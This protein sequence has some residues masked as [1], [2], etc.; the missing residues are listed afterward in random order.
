MD[1]NDSMI[2]A[3]DER[4]ND[5]FETYDCKPFPV[6]NVPNL[7]WLRILDL[8]GQH[9]LEYR[10]NR[11]GK[12]DRKLAH[13]FKPSAPGHRYCPRCVALT[14]PI[15]LLR[16]VEQSLARAI[17][18]VDQEM[19]MVIDQDIELEGCDMKE[20]LALC[21]TFHDMMKRTRLLR[22]DVEA[23]LAKEPGEGE[24][25][26]HD[27]RVTVVDPAY[28]KVYKRFSGAPITPTRVDDMI[29]AEEDEKEEKRIEKETEEIAVRVLD[30]QAP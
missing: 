16:Q 5:D 25:C 6:C 4:S 2:S 24:Y 29:D 17:Q 28:Q 11:N 7:K 23:A 15:R 20:N 27:G 19:G 12:L 10:L 8:A 14:E 3:Q 30:L 26:R 1:P 9:N 13:R 21:E 18:L 22:H